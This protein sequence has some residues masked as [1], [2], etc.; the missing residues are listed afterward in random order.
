MLDDVVVA[1]VATPFVDVDVAWF[2]AEAV[3]FRDVAVVVRPLAELD[4]ARAVVVTDAAVVGRVATVGRTVVLGRVGVPVGPVVDDAVVV[5]AAVDD[6]VVVGGGTVTNL[7]TICAVQVT[8]DPPPFAE[9]LH[10]LMVIGIAAATVDGFTV[11]L[12]RR[13]A[14]PP[15]AEPLHWVMSAPV[16]LD[17]GLHAVVG[18]VPSAPDPMH[19]LTVAGDVELS[20]VI[21]L[22]TSTVHV[23]LPPAPLIE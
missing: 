4:V 5:G 6:G 15:L 16:V 3:L 12:T 14:P 18:A 7:F 2:T 10:W 22:V 23:R 20:P 21:V 11:Q 8:V 1:P 17:V 9:L 13:A 19:W